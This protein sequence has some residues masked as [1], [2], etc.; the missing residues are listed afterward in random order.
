M[1]NTYRKLVEVLE[2]K[3][4]SFE[5]WQ[6][7]QLKHRMATEI[8]IIKEREENTIAVWDIKEQR[9]QELREAKIRV[10]AEPLVNYKEWY[11]PYDYL[12]T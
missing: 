8:E 11:S 3:W 7:P 10:K 4:N 1:I 12:Y 5:K 9:K 2:K 6:I